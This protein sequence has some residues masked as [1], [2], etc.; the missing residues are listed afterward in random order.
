M[1]Q[2]GGGKERIKN[3]ERRPGLRCRSGQATPPPC[4]TGRDVE[5]R[6]GSHSVGIAAIAAA[7]CR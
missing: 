3:R 2:R 5:N 1:I 6:A 4:D 7:R